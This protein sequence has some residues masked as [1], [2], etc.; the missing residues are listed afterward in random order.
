MGCLQAPLGHG[1]PAPA[2]LGG[3]GPGLALPTTRACPA[4]EGGGR[5]Q[6][7]HEPYT[8]K[9]W[10][11]LPGGSNGKEFTFNA[12]DWGSIPGLGMFLG[13]GNGNP[14]QYSCLE[15]SLDRGTWRAIQSLG[16]KGRTRLGG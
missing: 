13:E 3:A 1:R 15:N 2:L 7:R 12:G 11:R 6:G 9:G 4:W 8:I 5:F 14:L 10:P 16:H